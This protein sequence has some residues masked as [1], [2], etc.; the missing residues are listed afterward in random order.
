MSALENIS[1]HGLRHTHA[2]ILIS[3]GVPPITIAES[4]GEYFGND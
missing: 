4:A 3:N 1:P 2:T